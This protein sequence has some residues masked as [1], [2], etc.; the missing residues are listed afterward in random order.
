MDNNGF[1]SHPF[2]ALLVYCALALFIVVAMVSV[3]YIAGGRRKHSVH[4]RPYES[5]MIPEGSTHIRLSVQYYL[6]GMFFLIFDIEAVFLFAWAISLV[7]V[8]WGA[9]ATMLIFVGVLMAGFVYLW[10]H[11]ALDAR[12]RA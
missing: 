6:M 10:K 4:E 3:S 2:G 1:F 5:G 8:G 11:G 12:L 7:K 9:Y